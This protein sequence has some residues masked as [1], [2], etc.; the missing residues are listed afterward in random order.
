VA[1]L[2]LVESSGR[3]T[4]GSRPTSADA[5]ANAS[6]QPK[7]TVI[8]RTPSLTVYGYET[9]DGDRVR[10]WEN[11]RGEIVARRLS[12][13]APAACDY[14]RALGLAPGEYGHEDGFPPFVC[15][16][17]YQEMGTS[18][19]PHGL[20]PKNALAY[21]VSGERVRVQDMKLVLNIH[22][23]HEAKQA[24]ATFLRAAQMLTEQALRTPLPKAG[25]RAMLAG[26]SWKGQASGATLT[27][28]R[29]NWPT[30]KGYDLIYVVHP[31]GEVP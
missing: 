4:P 23:R 12:R 25:E 24:H 3:D 26:Q 13:P 1:V 17:P 6:P 30:G 27:L 14:L 11:A 28:T 21:H 15:G 18:A 7:R 22:Q 20:G 31:K 16:T 5:D 19:D 29:T 10:E 2:L 9:A 8:Q